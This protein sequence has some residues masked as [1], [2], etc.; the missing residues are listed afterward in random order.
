MK[1]RVIGQ[2]FLYEQEALVTRNLHANMKA[3]SEMVKKL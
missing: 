2:N 3:L 1:V